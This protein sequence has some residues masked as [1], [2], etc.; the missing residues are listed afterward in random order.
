MSARRVPHVADVLRMQLKLLIGTKYVAAVAVIP[1]LSL[2]AFEIFNPL[3]DAP[4]WLAP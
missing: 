1:L 4:P 3:E 2:F